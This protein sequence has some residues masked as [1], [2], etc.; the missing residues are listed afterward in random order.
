MIKLLNGY[1]PIFPNVNDD[2]QDKYIT[3]WWECIS[4]LYFSELSTL[5]QEE[6]T[7][8]ELTTN[9]SMNNIWYKNQVN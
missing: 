3:A 1:I 8:I 4:V 6:L 9:K 7:L 2:K 5:T